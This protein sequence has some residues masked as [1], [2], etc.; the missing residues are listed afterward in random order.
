MQEGKEF[1]ELLLGKVKRSAYAKELINLNP[2]NPEI[3]SHKIEYTLEPSKAIVFFENSYFPFEKGIKAVKKSQPWEDPH[4]PPVGYKYASMLMDKLDEY[5][6]LTRE[7]I[8]FYTSVESVLDKFHNVDYFVEFNLGSFKEL[9]KVDI[10]MQPDKA[11]N[12]ADLILV[13]KN[14]VLENVESMNDFV[15]ASVES[16][17]GCVVQRIQRKQG[18]RA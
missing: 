11:L 6:G 18:V 10:T 4:N 15:N 17:V 7:N 8:Y 5:S 9:V 16:I 2:D 14:D 12:N 3:K 13:Y 1:E